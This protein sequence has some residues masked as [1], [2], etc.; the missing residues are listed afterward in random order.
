MPPSRPASGTFGP[1][2]PGAMLPPTS[3]PTAVGSTPPGSSG[4]LGTTPPMS[5]SASG[6]MLP[7]AAASRPQSSMSNASDADDILGSMAPRPRG[8]KKAVRKGRYVDVMA[9]QK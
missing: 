8:A 1:P 4:G 2:P 6:M 5:R 3:S 7:P 9:N